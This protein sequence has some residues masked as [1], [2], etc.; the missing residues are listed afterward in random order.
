M[1]LPLL[2]PFVPMSLLLCLQQSLLLLL[3]FVP[4]LLLLLLLAIGHERAPWSLA[5]LLAQIVTLRTRG[6]RS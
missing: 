1:P 6:T 5:L 3:V 4:L 2:L